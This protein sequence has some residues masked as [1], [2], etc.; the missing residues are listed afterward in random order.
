MS[1]SP[2]SPE[3]Y[4]AMV[5]QSIEELEEQLRDGKIEWPAYVIKKKAL[6]KML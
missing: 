3:Y 4:R 6:I 1:I 2:T 5:M